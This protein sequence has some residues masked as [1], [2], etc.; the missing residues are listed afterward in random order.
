[1]PELSGQALRAAIERAADEDGAA[2]A[3]MPGHIDEV[4]D[5]RAAAEFA[6]GDRRGV[7]VVLDQHRH[8]QKV[9]GNLAERDI[10]PTEIRA[11]N[12]VTAAVDQA[13]NADPHRAPRQPAEALSKLRHRARKRADGF[14]ADLLSRA[15]IH[16]R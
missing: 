2:D 1:M 15:A 13:R 16:G 12:Q 9:G 7:G 14:L 10:A 4:V 3:G 6:F 5:A 11:E 8:R